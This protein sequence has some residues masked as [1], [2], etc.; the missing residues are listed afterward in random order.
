[1]FA[2]QNLPPGGDPLPALDV[3]R[4]DLDR[5]TC[6]YDLHVRCHETADGISGWI[7]YSTALF[8][9]GTIADRLQELFAELDGEA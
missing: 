7:E 9:P 8:D 1:M 5:G 6:R 2:M 3:E 4:V